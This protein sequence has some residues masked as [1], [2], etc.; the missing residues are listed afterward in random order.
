MPHKWVCS[1]GNH[2]PVQV[3]Y[4]G[5]CGKHWSKATKAATK[6]AG[7]QSQTKKGVKDSQERVGL[8]SEFSIPSV[9]FSSSVV[10]PVSS[11]PLLSNGTQSQKT[12]KTL[13]HQRANRI[14]KVESKIL[15]LENALTEIKSTWPSYV[16]K[17]QQG[18]QQ[19]YQRCVTFSQQATAELAQLR[20]E[21]HGL[22]HSQLSMDVPD[23]TQV[24]IA[25]WMQSQVQSALQVL[26]AA[27]LLNI[28]MN[29]GPHVPDVHMHVQPDMPPVQNAQPPTLPVQEQLVPPSLMTPP[30]TEVAPIAVQGVISKGEMPSVSGPPTAPGNWT[31][32]PPPP[33]ASEFVLPELPS[34]EFPNPL[35]K[36]KPQ[37]DQEPNLQ[38]S[39]QEAAQ[40]TGVCLMDPVVQQAVQQAAEG[41][42][43]QHHQNGC[44]GGTSLPPEF[45]QML[46]QFTYQQAHC[47]LQLQGLKHQQQQPAGDQSTPS[48]AHETE[49]IHSSPGPRSAALQPFPQHFQLS[50]PGQRDLKI[51]KSVPG[52][53]HSQVNTAGANVPVPASP[54]G[55]SC[56]E[57]PATPPYV[58]TE[59]AESEP[60]EA[61]DGT[62][63]AP[64]LQ[65]LE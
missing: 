3:A 16:N 46:N 20:Q 43:A 34:D 21:L 41:L 12:M 1:C 65:Q 62:H 36:P 49:S 23:S 9:E 26:S 10:L 13:L 53:V 25:T 61:Q 55:Q 45:Q 29:T 35:Y 11:P 51:A 63:A 40:R 17:V 48:G 27:G 30:V 28:P 44:P 5:S 54:T 52:S 19:E 64:T 4:C 39:I 56:Q 24:Y 14:G 18:L 6:H 15:R 38:Q 58:P 8:A 2:V 7:A 31:W 57:L 42:A 50:P 59:I 37:V 47:H 60:E 33:Q 22:M 32:P